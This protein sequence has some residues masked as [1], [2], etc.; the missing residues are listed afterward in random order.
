[1]CTNFCCHHHSIPGV[2]RC[3]FG[4]RC[5]YGHDESDLTCS[6]VATLV[7]QAIAN[8]DW[9]AIDFTASNAGEIEAELERLSKMCW[10]HELFH[11]K[12][13]T[14]EATKDD[15]C[16]GGSL[17]CL[18]GVHSDAYL[19][20]KS[21]WENGV[22][23]GEPGIKLTTRGLIC[24]KAQLE[25]KAQAE[26]EALRRKR[27]EELQ[28]GPA[29]GDA[30]KPIAS[31]WGGKQM[32]WSAN[33]TQETKFSQPKL[34]QFTI[35]HQ[36]ETFE[37]EIT[38]EEEEMQILNGKPHIVK[39]IPGS[40]IMNMTRIY[41]IEEQAREARDRAFYSRVFAPLHMPR[42]ASEAP[43]DWEDE[44]E[45]E[46]SEF[47]YEGEDWENNELEEEEWYDEEEEYWSEIEYQMIKSVT[48]SGMTAAN[49]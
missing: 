45:G 42:S 4:N 17:T 23:D 25:A 44:V 18:A 48:I 9:S 22:D 5:N 28:A 24:K 31:S 40:K 20:N 3:R 32:N 21:D 19:L 11:T 1:M 7:Q 43:E 16:P 30:P 34:G 14:N 8:Q 37:Y 6:P 49:A 13:Q 33:F 12:L 15:F 27:L 38:N 46:I 26:A 10:R 2:D 29:L 36:G 41:S 39:P 35:E 47:E